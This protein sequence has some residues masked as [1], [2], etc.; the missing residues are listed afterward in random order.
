VK[1]ASIQKL[2]PEEAY[3]SGKS[4]DSLDCVL[5]LSHPNKSMRAHLKNSHA[6]LKI[7]PR[8]S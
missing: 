1:L 4:T 7:R 3:I 6:A 8:Y 2:F 5:K